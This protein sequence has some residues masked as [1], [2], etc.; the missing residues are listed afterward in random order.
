LTMRDKKFEN[1]RSN[2]GEGFTF[3]CVL[4]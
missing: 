2:E 4:C 3:L 1:V